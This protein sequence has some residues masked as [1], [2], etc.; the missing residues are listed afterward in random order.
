MVHWLPGQASSRSALGARRDTLDSADRRSVEGL[1]RAVSVV[2][3][4][5][6]PFSAMDARGCFQADTG[7]ACRGPAGT[8]RDRPVGSF[9][10]R[11]LREREKRG[12]AVGKTKRGKGTKVMAVADRGGLPVAVHVT[13]ASPHEVTLVEET[14]DRLWTSAPPER[15][16]G[17]KAYDSDELDRRLLEERSI[18]VIAPHRSNRRRGATQ[19]GRALRRYKRRWKVERLHAWLQNFRRLV[20]RYEYHATNFL[21]M[22]QLGCIIILLR[23]F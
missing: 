8:R 1:A 10:R 5:P 13:S 15:L 19:D 14:L 16:L 18:E 6:P 22:V 12:L 4:L 2:P 20:V 7:G 9:Y 11:L 3:D 21:A 23:H 17:D